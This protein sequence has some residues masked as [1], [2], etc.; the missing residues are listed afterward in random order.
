MHSKRAFVAVIVL[1]FALGT[2]WPY[3][4]WSE[5]DGPDY[6]AVKNVSQDDHLNLRKGPSIKFSVVAPI[7]SGFLHLENL[8]CSPVLT[9]TDWERF[10]EY[11]RDV[12]VSLRWCRVRFHD[13]VG[14]VK[15]SYLQEGVPLEN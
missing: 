15:G 1:G 2:S 9:I 4:A 8:G 3:L 10:S 13:H 12:A 6:W 11:E 5:A 14:W 7:P